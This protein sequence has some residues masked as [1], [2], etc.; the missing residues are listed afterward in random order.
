VEVLVGEIGIVERVLECSEDKEKE[1]YEG[2]D[3]C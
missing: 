2:D 1:T 3:V